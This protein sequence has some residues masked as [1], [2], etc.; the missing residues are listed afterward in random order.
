MRK[1]L[2]SNDDVH[3]DKTGRFTLYS[4]LQKMAF[5]MIQENSV[6][7]HVWK[8][9]VNIFPPLKRKHT[10]IFINSNITND[11]TSNESSSSIGI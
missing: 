5:F 7:E 11:I 2:T 8:K 3:T 9:V 6:K 10:A 1:T 4:L